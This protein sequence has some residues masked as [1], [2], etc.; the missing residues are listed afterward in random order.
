MDRAKAIQQLK[1]CQ[2]NGDTEG[3][4]CE[5]DSIICALL[6]SLGYEDVTKEYHAVDKWFA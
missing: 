3:A 2:A 6:D 1:E 5:A 4:H